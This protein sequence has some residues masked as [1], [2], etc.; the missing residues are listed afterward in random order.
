MALSIVMKY[1]FTNTSRSALGFITKLG[2]MI[3]NFMKNN[4]KP[5]YHVWIN[6]LCSRHFSVFLKTP[7]MLYYMW[8]ANQCYK[9]TS[10]YK[11]SSFWYPDI[12]AP[13]LLT[14]KWRINPKQNKVG[15]LLCK[16]LFRVV[17]FCNIKMWNAVIIYYFWNY[18]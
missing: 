18:I 13:P 3:D 8:H 16:S 15:L 11:T 14:A 9:W 12:S 5:I 7:V 1:T 2:Q 17:F 6:G 10:V 4:L